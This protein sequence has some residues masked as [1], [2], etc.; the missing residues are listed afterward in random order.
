MKDSIYE[1][2]FTRV[3]CLGGLY[4][5]IG[6]WMQLGDFSEVKLSGISAV[7]RTVRPGVRRG[8]PETD[9]NSWTQVGVAH[10]R[11]LLS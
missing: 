8:V 1:T 6:G 11:S 7:F 4:R 3:F 9:R 2:P 10:A 5:H